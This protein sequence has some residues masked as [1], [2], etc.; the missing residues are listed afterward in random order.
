MNFVLGEDNPHE[1]DSSKP[2]DHQV[3]PE[4][5]CAVLFRRPLYGAQYELVNDRIREIQPGNV[6]FVVGMRPY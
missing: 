1:Y 2:D 3:H 5:E 4:V 6:V